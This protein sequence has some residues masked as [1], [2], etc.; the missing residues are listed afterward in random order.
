MLT[1]HT[2]ALARILPKVRMTDFRRV[3][4]PSAN[5]NAPRY[6][7]RVNFLPIFLADFTRFFLFFGQYGKSRLE[8]WKRRRPEMVLQR[9]SRVHASD[10][11][12]R[13]LV[14]PSVQFN[15]IIRFLIGETV[16]IEQ[17]EKSD[18]VFSIRLGKEGD[19]VW[20]QILLK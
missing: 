13:D 14:R 16:G 7:R 12:D 10:T 1:L 5:E 6:A 18:S 11:I 20:G 2:L 17:F 3:H 8:G 19:T 9:F 15:R 4:K